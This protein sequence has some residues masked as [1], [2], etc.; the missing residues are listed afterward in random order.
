MCSPKIFSLPNELLVAITAAGQQDRVAAL[1]TPGSQW[2]VHSDTFK[3]EWTLSQLSHRFRDVVIGAPVLWTLTE[4]D[5][6][7]AGSMEILNLY[8]VRSQSCQIAITL[9]EPSDSDEEDS[10]IRERIHQ[11]LPHI[12]R[13][14]RLRI[15]LR[16]EGPVEKS[17]RD[18][19]APHLEHL[20]I[21]NAFDDD[22][23]TVGMFTS[24]APG[25]SF[26]KLDRIDFEWTA[27][28]WTASLTHLDLSTGPKGTEDFAA[29]TAQ[30]PLLV[31]LRVNSS[32]RTH[33]AGAPRFH[34]PTLKSLHISIS[35]DQDSD[36]LS[37][38]MDLFDTP[39]VTKLE[40][41]DTHA[42]QI[43]VLFNLTSLPHSSFAA[44]TSVTFASKG[45]SCEK[46]VPFPRIII[47]QPPLALFPALSHLTLVNQCFTHNLVQDLLGPTSQPWP[48]LS[49]VALYPPEGS[50]EDVRNALIDAVGPRA[51]PFIQV[52]DQSHRLRTFFIWQSRTQTTNQDSMD[53]EMVVLPFPH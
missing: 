40:V 23:F 39:A 20:E 7:H 1:Y 29:L 42:D 52:V 49:T 48:L 15:S 6:G 9:R 35:E 22:E 44:L 13:I 47:S 10:L 43:C 50:L 3:S 51:Q 8:L 2:E 38:I 26:L 34:I 17:F 16:E 32:M 14:R 21:S 18:I 45:C 41:N 28:P 12:N 4:A 33:A 11:V 19:A 25:L 31:H 37:E 5:V 27:A 30:F 24:G 36:Y 46:E 53:V